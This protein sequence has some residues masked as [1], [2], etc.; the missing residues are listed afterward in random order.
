MDDK[1]VE[2]SQSVKNGLED[3]RKIFVGH[4]NIYFIS[5]SS[6]DNNYGSNIALIGTQ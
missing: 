5:D 4:Y 2:V 1:I 3:Y 6:Y